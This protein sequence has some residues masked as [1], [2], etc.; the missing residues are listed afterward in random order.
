MKYTTCNS[1]VGR[2][3]ERNRERI[4]TELEAKGFHGSIRYLLDYVFE[5]LD[6]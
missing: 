5:K 1:R 2:R 3:A 6:P 4:E